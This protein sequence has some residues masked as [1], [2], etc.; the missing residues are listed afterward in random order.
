MTGP[1]DRGQLIAALRGRADTLTHCPQ[2]GDRAKFAYG[3]PDNGHEVAGFLFEQ[4]ILVCPRA[5][6][7]RFVA[8]G[9]S[10]ITVLVSGNHQR[11]LDGEIGED[12]AS[13]S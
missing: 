2:C 3:R 13:G 7:G 5:P 6:A 1:L 4:P 12:S 9:G 8:V 11:A 10:A